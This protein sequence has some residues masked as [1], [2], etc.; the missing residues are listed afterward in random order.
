MASSR[1]N[2]RACF[3]IQKAPLNESFRGACL[4]FSEVSLLYYLVKLKALRV[5][6]NKLIVDSFAQSFKNGNVVFTVNVAVDTVLH[7][8]PQHQISKAG[9]LRACEKRWIVKSRNYLLRLHFMCLLQ[10][11]LQAY[12]F[13]I[14][15][16]SVGVTE[17]F[18]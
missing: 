4:F 17:A 12:T 16:F 6:G 5:A 10:G 7:A 13:A 3:C 2:S 9:V 18:G 1:R 11:K 14:V 8:V 15:N